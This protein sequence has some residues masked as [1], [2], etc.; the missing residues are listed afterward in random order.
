MT[1]DHDDVRVHVPREE[2]D[3]SSGEIN[4]LIKEARRRQRLR[5][6]FATIA[7]IVLVVAVVVGG[8]GLTSRGGLNSTSP[9]SRVATAALKVCPLHSLAISLP[10]SGAG[11]GHIAYDIK[12]RN[13]SRLSCTLSGYPVVVAPL[14]RAAPNGAPTVA[15]ASD[16][17]SGYSGGIYG[18]TKKM[19]VY[20]RHLPVVVLR[21][22]GYASVVVEY[23]DLVRAGCPTYTK[24]VVTLPQGGRAETFTV[25]ARGELC[26]RLVVH[27]ILSGFTGSLD[28]Q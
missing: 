11:L 7:L 1:I 15:R 28:A 24:F 14:T 16:Q 9:H 25:P 20:E 18:S 4:V 23:G 26:T 12:M 17:M 13:T 3:G 10:S 8:L 6:F 22:H 27:P 5:Y 21:P 2:D 19:K